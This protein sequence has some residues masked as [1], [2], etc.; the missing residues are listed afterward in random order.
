MGS[1]KSPLDLMD[2][3]LEGIPRELIAPREAHGRIP[4]PH[5]VTRP[6]K[7]AAGTS[8]ARLKDKFAPL[9]LRPR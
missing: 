8:V 9:P 2:D 1:N 5:A 3:K 6:C 4:H 7:Q